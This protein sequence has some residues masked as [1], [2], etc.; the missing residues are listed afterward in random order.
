MKPVA[1]SEATAARFM[2]H[3]AKD[4]AT[5]CWNWTGYCDPKGYGRFQLG[6]T[7]ARMA[8]Q[9]SYGLFVG[10]MEDGLELDHLCRN[11]SCVNP[12]HLEPVTQEVNNERRIGWRRGAPLTHCPQGHE[13]TPE[14]SYYDPK[15]TRF[16]R[17]CKAASRR[18]HKEKQKAERAARGHKKRGK[19]LATH[20]QNGHP[21]DEVNLY[22]SPG[23]I[24][25]CKTCKAARAKAAYA[26]RKAPIEQ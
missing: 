10:H 1:Y 23:G 3:V 9:V 2:R 6:T 7:D 4:E 11:T 25:A 14:N 8:H 20:C 13:Y 16:C 15:G 21:L 22:V 26:A 5:G 17:T 12:E 18:A 24:R 19:P